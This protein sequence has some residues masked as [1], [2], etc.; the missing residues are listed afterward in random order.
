M[1]LDNLKI[2]LEKMNIPVAYSH[3]VSETNPPYLVYYV[4]GSD[5]T[6]ADNTVYYE[7]LNATIELY[8]T[9]KDLNL[10]N[11][12]KDILNANEIPYEITTETYINTE[13]IYQIVFEISL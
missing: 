1:T 7:N 11:K 4:D 3:F 2:E 5:N 10:E 9:K 13:K 12:L 6:F 8:S